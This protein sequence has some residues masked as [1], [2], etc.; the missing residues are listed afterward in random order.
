MIFLKNKKKL[1]I[2]LLIAAAVVFIAGR[3]LGRGRKNA[4]SGEA[5][6]AAMDIAQETVE[7]A[8]IERTVAGSGTIAADEAAEV[9]V[10][11]GIKVEKVFVKEGEHVTEGQQI[12]TVSELSVK[13]KLLEVQQA[14]DRLQEEI[15][16]LDGS[17]DNYDL[18]FD[19]KYGQQEELIE[20][21]G[22]LRELLERTVLVSTATGQVQKVNIE[23]NTEI[24]KYST[25]T[26]TDGDSS[27]YSDLFSSAA[28]A[29]TPRVTTLAARTEKTEQTDQPA[30]T[31]TQAQQEAPGEEG[32]GDVPPTILTGAIAIPV[33]APVT[34][35]APASFTL[36]EGFEQFMEGTLEWIPAVDGKFA[37]G[38]VYQ[39][40]ITLKALDGFAFDEDLTRLDITVPGVAAP[41]VR[42]LRTGTSEVIDTVRIAAA[43][44]ATAVKE[45]QGKDPSTEPTTEK[46]EPGTNPGTDPVTDPTTEPGT[47]PT[48]EDAAGIP[49]GD[50][51][52]LDGMSGLS[53]LGGLGGG[54]INLGG[55]SGAGGASSALSS[56]SVSNSIDAVGS[57]AYSTSWTAGITVVPDDHVM[58][59]IQ[60]SEMDVLS[61]HEGQ[62]AQVRIDAL[63]GQT[64]TGTIQSVA[65]TAS[66]SG[67]DAVRYKVS[68]RLD[69]TPEMLYGMSASA[70]II[71]EKK[72][73]V[74]TVPMDALQTIEGKTMVYTAVDE[75]GNLVAPVEVTTGASDAE[76]AEILSGLAV[77]DTI[78]YHRTSGTGNMFGDR[79][80]RP[81]G[82]GGPDGR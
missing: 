11:V 73:N 75:Q 37:P 51:S 70:T 78:Y 25:S 69:K 38:T 29:V 4:L 59:E 60:V 28:P 32:S 66:S 12:A 46:T 48:T 57:S 71:T 3:A 79:E 17:E 82:P 39:A 14:I 18:L 8:S 27:S 1:I 63:G 56:Y 16:D 36:P 10:P 72:E 64:F 77:G 80:D 9:A 47:M 22:E 61:V 58:L 52:G 44:P 2:G 21:R 30:E 7:T 54:T 43:F 42:L 20:T 41:S 55:F 15:D 34:G 62:E 74:P 81:E 76:R 45:G 24:V 40:V 5:L 50:F 33:T 65:T 23:D 31:T 26:G 67:G 49:G 35:A 19:I 13:E 53:G 68:I 6:L